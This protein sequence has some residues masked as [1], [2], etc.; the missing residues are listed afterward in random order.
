MHKTPRIKPR[1]P[2]RNCSQCKGTGHVWL[3]SR[4]PCQACDGVGRKLFAGYVWVPCN[5]E[6]HSNPHID[7]CMVCL[8]LWGRVPAKA[9]AFKVW[10]RG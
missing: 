9:Y 8:P 1:K 2:Y 5:G 4:V 3:G 10:V 7:H 6:A